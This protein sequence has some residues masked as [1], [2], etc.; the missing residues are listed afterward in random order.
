MN[1]TVEDKA[2]A[3]TI[4]ALSLIVLIATLVTNQIEI[5]VALAMLL[6]YFVY[7]GLK[8]SLTNKQKAKDE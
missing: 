1:A 4:L 8:K 5:G 2:L 7:N 3:Y 6:F